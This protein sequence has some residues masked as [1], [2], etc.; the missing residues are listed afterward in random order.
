MTDAVSYESV[1]CVQKYAR[2]AAYDANTEMA[3]DRRYPAEWANSKF[4]QRLVH[5][6]RMSQAVLLKLYTTFTHRQFE[7][8]IYNGECSMYVLQEAQQMLR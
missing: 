8:T 2:T 3:T 1:L 7:E 5:E 4:I 6:R